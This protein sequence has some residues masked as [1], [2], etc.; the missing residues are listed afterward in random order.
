[1]RGC[2]A[3]LLLAASGFGL[4]L[5][6][7][8]DAQDECRLC[9]DEGVLRQRERQ[10][11]VAPLIISLPPDLTGE[12]A[13]LTDA[14]RRFPI[15]D[16]ETKPKLLRSEPPAFPT[17]SIPRGVVPGGTVTVAFTIERDGSV[18]APAIV[19]SDTIPSAYWFDEVAL[20]SIVKWK[21]AAVEARC[22]GEAKMT[23]R[24]ADD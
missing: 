22:R 24:L 7:V 17:R 14:L 3:T 12:F 9:M 8:A 10:L 21:Y 18:S 11:P 13:S 20:D 2:V 5:M 15:I 19:G 6:S 4:S 16:C 1:M 23:F